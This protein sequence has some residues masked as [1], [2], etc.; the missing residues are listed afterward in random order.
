MK[1]VQQQQSSGQQ[2]RHILPLTGAPPA[3]DPTKRTDT[4]EDALDVAPPAK[5]STLTR[6]VAVV[7]YGAVSGSL[8]F[9]N[10]AVVSVYN[11]QYP[12]TILALQMAVSIAV[13]QGAKRVRTAVCPRGVAACACVVS[14]CVHVACRGVRRLTL[15]LLVPG[16]TT[17]RLDRAPRVERKDCTH[18]LAGHCPVFH[19]RPV[20]AVVAQ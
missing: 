9:F 6:I 3:C 1:V 17:V 15:A 20:R 14:W 2:Q 16:A 12:L 18:H 4:C 11:F 7:T 5:A 10:K 19:Q 8:T 13:L